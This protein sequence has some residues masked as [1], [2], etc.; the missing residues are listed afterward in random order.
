MR[1]MDFLQEEDG[2]DLV[3]YALLVAFVC[4]AGAALYNSMAT[5]S[6]FVIQGIGTRTNSA[7]QA[8]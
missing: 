1:W 8:S 5:S 4:L 3:E 6:L 2:Q 7:N